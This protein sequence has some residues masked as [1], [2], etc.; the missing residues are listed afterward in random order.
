MIPANGES[1]GAHHDSKNDGDTKA[2]SAY[3]DNLKITIVD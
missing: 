1:F 3:F 2:V